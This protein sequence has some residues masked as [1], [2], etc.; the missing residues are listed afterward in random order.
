MNQNDLNRQ[1]SARTG[2]SIQTVRRIG[3]SPL[4]AVI[5]VEERGQPLVVDWDLEQSTR[6]RRSYS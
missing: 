3:F 2:E 6:Y 1:V 4:L 5:P